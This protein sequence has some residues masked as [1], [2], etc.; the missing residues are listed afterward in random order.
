MAYDPNDYLANPGKY[1][2]FRTATIARATVTG[3]GE[4]LE[5][6]ETVGVA[7]RCEAY[8]A[9]RR[10]SEPVYAITRVDGYT[11]DGYGSILSGFVL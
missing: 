3:D 4:T 5:P 8:N 10:R 7:F 2:L 9:L 11:F 6:G 1:R